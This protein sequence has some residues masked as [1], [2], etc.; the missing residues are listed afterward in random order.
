MLREDVHSRE[1]KMSAKADRAR[2]AKCASPSGVRGWEADMGL[3]TL[4]FILII[5]ERRKD[6]I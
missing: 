3:P 4:F 5:I 6:K 1:R 2:H